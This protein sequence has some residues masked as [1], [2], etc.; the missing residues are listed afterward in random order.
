MR[1]FAALRSLSHHIAVPC[2]VAVAIALFALDV[3]GVHRQEPLF[4]AGNLFLRRPEF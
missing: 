2:A 3:R 1:P 4:S